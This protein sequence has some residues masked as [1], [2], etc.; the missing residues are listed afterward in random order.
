[1]KKIALV[2]AILGSLGNCFAAPEDWEEGG[3]YRR[4]MEE[5]GKCLENEGCQTY[6]REKPFFQ[7]DGL[8]KESDVAAAWSEEW[9][10]TCKHIVRVNI[11]G[12]TAD[13]KTVFAP[14][15]GTGALIDIGVPALLGRVVITCRHNIAMDGGNERV[16]SSNMKADASSLAMQSGREGLFT[17]INGSSTYLSVT[18][19][20]T[21][22]DSDPPLINS[23]DEHQRCRYKVERIY[24]PKSG[25]DVAILVLEEPI[26]DEGRSLGLREVFSNVWRASEGED[27]IVNG[28]DTKAFVIGY[29]MTGVEQPPQE[30]FGSWGEAVKDR[31]LST[32]Q[33]FLKNLGFNKKKLIDI[34]STLSKSFIT[35]TGQVSGTSKSGGGF[36]GSLVIA[37]RKG[38]AENKYVGI[39]S[40][41]SFTSPW[42]RITD[43]IDSVKVEELKI[44][45]S[46][47]DF[48]AAQE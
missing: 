44:L 39:L 46:T 20:L 16:E 30:L 3:K 25:F 17:M 27:Q 6:R 29:G 24:H 34:S 5:F 7:R 32:R 23:I 41:V 19:E 15:I 38:S 47:T 37:R 42:F 36:S 21:E 4:N 13:D 22:K 18:P 10:D 9:K 11:L 12:N 1:M 26:K 35:A 33:D 48:N 45:R 8:Y 31:K 43:F 40:G 2:S 28:Q 14:T